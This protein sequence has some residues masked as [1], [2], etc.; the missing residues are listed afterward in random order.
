MSTDMQFI[1]ARN[2]SWVRDVIID[3]NKSFNA[4][5]VFLLDLGI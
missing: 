3:G 1:T 5:D 2:V 4:Y